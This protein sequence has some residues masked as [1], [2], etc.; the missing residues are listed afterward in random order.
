MTGATFVANEVVVALEKI[1]LEDGV[2]V[3]ESAMASVRSVRDSSACLIR[4]RMGG[5]CLLSFV[6][7]IVWMRGRFGVRVRVRVR[8]RVEV[9]AR[10]RVRVRVR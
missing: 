8:V 6:C 10:V 3:I 2:P 1:H 5:A 4:I 7:R 9:K